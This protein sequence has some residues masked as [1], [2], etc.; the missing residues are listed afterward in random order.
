MVNRATHNTAI[1]MINSDSYISFFCNALK[2]ISDFIFN[3]QDDQ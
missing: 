1:K 3:Y 2:F